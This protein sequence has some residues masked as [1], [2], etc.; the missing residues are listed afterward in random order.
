MSVLIMIERCE[1]ELIGFINK[2]ILQWWLY[3]LTRTT[4]H[5]KPNNQTQTVPSF[6]NNSTWFWQAISIITTT[7]A[8]PTNLIK[9][10]DQNTKKN[11]SRTIVFEIIPSRIK[12]HVYHIAFVQT[13]WTNLRYICKYNST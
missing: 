11:Y 4:G 5:N 10:L 1:K 6:V 2:Y 9:A 12:F 8:Q 3:K 7:L 13:E